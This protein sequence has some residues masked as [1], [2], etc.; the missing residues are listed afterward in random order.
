L[1]L[2]F[3]GKERLKRQL[4]IAVCYQNDHPHDLLQVS[5]EEHLTNILITQI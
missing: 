5:L 3:G 4:I 2:H 1:S